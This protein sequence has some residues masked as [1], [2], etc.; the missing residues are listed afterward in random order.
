MGKGF[1]FE[2]IKIL[3]KSKVMMVTHRRV[4]GP[5]ATE[6]HFKRLMLCHVNFTTIF[7]NCALMSEVLR[8]P[9]LRGADAKP[10]TLG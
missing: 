6:L 1:P 2:L 10:L 8:Q 7:K 3:W 9:V 5:P 4:N